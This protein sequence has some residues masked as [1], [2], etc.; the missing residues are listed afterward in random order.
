MPRV[1]TSCSAEI[2]GLPKLMCMARLSALL[3]GP[4]TVTLLPTFSV[5]RDLVTDVSFDY[6][7]AQRISSFRPPADLAPASAAW[8]GR[9]RSQ[10]GV[11]QVH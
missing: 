9:R 11:P 8:T 3:P 6:R 2:N 7:M 4:V 5:I 10:P 1:A